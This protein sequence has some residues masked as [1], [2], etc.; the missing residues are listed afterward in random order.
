MIHPKPLAKPQPAPARHVAIIMDG[1][2]RWARERGFEPSEG[3]R[4]GARALRAAARTAIDL[5]IEILTVFAFSEEN[6]R[7]TPDEVEGLFEL[8]RSFARDEC[9]ALQ[10]AGVRVRVIGRVDALPPQTRLALGMLVSA[11]AANTG[12]LLNLAVNYGARTEMADAMRALVSDVQSGRLAI[13]AIDDESLSRYLY[14]AGLPDPDLL[15]RTGG[16]LRLSNFLLY[17][18]AYTELWSTP[19]HWPDFDASAF[20]QALGSFAGR[21]RRFGS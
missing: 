2:R 11:T 18:I 17:Q 20:A 4:Q 8:I 16:E 7:R 19:I 1:N 3:H 12:L 6:R 14:T 9:A 21:Q 15:I 13:E 10:E 5:G